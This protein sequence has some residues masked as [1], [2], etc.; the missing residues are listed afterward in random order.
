VTLGQFGTSGA[1]LTSEMTYSTFAV[2]SSVKAGSRVTLGVD[3]SYSKAQEEAD[4]LGLAASPEILAKLTG[5][6][7]DFST[8]HTYVDLNSASWDATARA[9]ARFTPTL[10]GIVSYTF[11]EFD[12][13]AAYLTDLSG[14]LDIVRL[15]L[16]WAF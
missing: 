8:W 3:V 1:L 6:T 4:P 15:A 12:D 5:F 11:L 14:N 7:Y 16:R 13:K 10:S 2:G 9:E